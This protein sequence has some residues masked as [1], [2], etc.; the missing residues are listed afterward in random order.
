MGSTLSWN[1]AGK[2]GNDAP[3]AR[4]ELVQIQ[5]K[6]AVWATPSLYVAASLCGSTELIVAPEVALTKVPANDGM[7]MTRTDPAPVLSPSEVRTFLDCQ[8]RWWFKYGLQLP[9]SKTSSLALGLA[10]H[11]ALEVNF[12]EKVE[13]HEDL[14]TA[15]VVMIF[16]DAWMEQAGRTQFAKDESQQDIRRVGERLVA[17]YMDEVAPTIEPAAVELEVQGEI[18]GVSVLG[19]VDVMDVDGQLIDIKT[20]A[21]RPSCVSADYAFQLATYRQITPGA[22]GQVRID[23]LIKTI[24][25]QIVQQSYIVGEADLRN[26]RILFP[27]VQEAMGSGMYCPNRQSLLCS[28]KHCGFWKHC[29]QEFG[30]TI[31]SS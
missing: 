12:R 29:E 25:P 23:S 30:G 19:R 8:A 7:L 26:T 27:L 11:R 3:T 17:K 14:D 18:S 2:S 20:A 13:T 4:R 1:A 24:T 6:P 22:S 9:D 10:I 31:R 28:Q 5:T 16:R 21:R 15:G